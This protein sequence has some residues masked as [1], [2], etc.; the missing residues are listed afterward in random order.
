MGL[1]D[2]EIQNDLF[3]AHILFCHEATFMKDGI[4]NHKNS[5]WQD[6][7]NP[8]ETNRAH[9]QHRVSANICC[10]ITDDR[11][12]R[13]FMSKHYLTAQKYL[14]FLKTACHNY[15]KCTS[16][17]GMWFQYSD[18]QLHFATYARKVFKPVVWRYLDLPQRATGLAIKAP[19]KMP[20]DY[21][22]WSMWTTLF[23]IWNTKQQHS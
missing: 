13:P 1:C 16:W 20:L 5:H 15:W 23:M 11:L 14:N 18:A 9:I 21:Y 17:K 8:N 6:F 2:G 10:G 12:I 3:T 4:T 22:L 7:E 19:N